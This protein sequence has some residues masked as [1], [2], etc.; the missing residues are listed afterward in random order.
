MICRAERKDHDEPDFMAFKSWFAT[1]KKEDERI[2]SLE[3]M[4]IIYLAASIYVVTYREPFSKGKI[5]NT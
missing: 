3:K 4:A 5:F 2:Y 1:L